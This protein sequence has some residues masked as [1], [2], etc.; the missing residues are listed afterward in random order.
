M[1]EFAGVKFRNPVVVAS[2]PL[3]VKPFLLKNAWDQGAAA[4]STKLTFIKQSF[5][6]RLRMYHDPKLGSIICA[7]R[8]LDQEEGVRLIEET[9]RLAP[10]LV[11]FANINHEGPDLE[12]WGVL[13]KAM[14][15]AGADL[16]EANFICPNLTLTA[17]QLGG[18]AA[19]GGALTGQNPDLAREVVRI[20]K[21]AVG[22]PVVP[23]LTPNVTDITAVAQACAEGGADGL[24]MAGA[25]MSLPPVDLYNL[26]RVY[27]LSV[28]ASFGSLG[29]QACQLQGYAMVAQ[30]AR[31]VPLPIVGGGGIFNWQHAAQ[32]ML[33]GSNLVAICTSLMWYGFE[34]IPPLL[35]GLEKYLGQMG[36]AS[37]DDLVGKALPTIRPAAD[38]EMIVDAPAVDPAR[39]NGCGVC[40]RP[41]HCYAITMPD[42]LPIID[43]E[44]CLGCSVCVA[45]CPR[46]A[47]SFPTY[48]GLRTSR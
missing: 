16:I 6:K 47:L 37:Y 20:L 35:N 46:K 29:G 5:Y 4:A 36:F 19:L 39:C 1:I 8:R 24:S 40:L 13:A 48:A 34:L 9:K 3:T 15:E 12:Q 21:G 23:K 7:D 41:G 27:D 38:L 44:K 14:E 45:I 25:Q 33:W 28:G 11:L 2:S 32:Y 18:G 30:T 31:R 26:D 17:R 42:K 22:I 10:D 43:A